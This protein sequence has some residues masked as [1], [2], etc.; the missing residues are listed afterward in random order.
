MKQLLNS[1]LVW[2]EDNT[3]VTVLRV[4]SQVLFKIVHHCVSSLELNAGKS[5]SISPLSYWAF[6]G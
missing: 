3:F 6:Q 4:E 1:A 5:F 2:Y